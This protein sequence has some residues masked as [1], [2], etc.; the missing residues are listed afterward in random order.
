M[1]DVVLLSIVGGVRFESEWLM[2]PVVCGL[3]LLAVLLVGAAGVAQTTLHTGTSLVVVPTLVET[4]DQHPVYSL[5]AEDFALTDD[6]VRQKVTVDAGTSHPLSLVVLIQT[7]G[8]A[9]VQFANFANLETML[10]SLLDGAPNR[11]AIVNF[12]SRPEGASPFTSNLAEWK[13]AINEPDQG[14]RGAAI[15]D[16][17]AF[18]IGL[19]KNEPANNRHAILLISQERDAGSKIKEKEIVR[20][21]GETNTAIYSLTF[22]AE[23]T[24]FRQAL[25]D[26]PHLNPPLFGIGDA[27][28]DLSDPL[29]R[30][31]GGLQKNMSAEVAGLSGGESSGFDTNNELQNALNTLQNHMAN[32]Y[33]LSFTPTSDAPGLHRLGVGVVRHP[34]F[35]V[36]ARGS[37]WAADE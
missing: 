12:D 37:Y 4:Q 17:I 30:A 21:L 6:G 10:S 36:S 16:A 20:R 15:Y 13:D 1:T 5:T 29:R 24:E 28:F 25:K 23:K 32:G 19:L 8:I 18:G 11:A 26:P 33:V 27:Y 14:D 35:I 22:S 2:R 7:G 3:K 34:E 9:R 31:L